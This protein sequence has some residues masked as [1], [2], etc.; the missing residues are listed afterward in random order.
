LRLAPPISS[1]AV[2]VKPSALAALLVPMVRCTPLL[3]PGLLAAWLTAIPLPA[4]ATGT[5]GE[6]RPALGATTGSE[7]ENGHSL[8]D[9]AA[10]SG[11]MLQKG[12]KGQSMMIDG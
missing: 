2:A 9:R 3:A 1:L 11:I 5:D 4:V 10:H 6:H 8:I 12:E 7:S